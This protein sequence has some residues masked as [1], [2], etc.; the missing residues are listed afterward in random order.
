MATTEEAIAMLQQ[1]MRDEHGAVIL[2]L[3]HAYFM[4]EGEEAAEIEQVARDEMRHFKWLAQAITQLG[5]VPTL[6]RTAMEV[7][8][9]VAAQWMR[10][11][12][13]AEQ[14]AIAQ[15]ERHRD[16]IA[17]PRVK[18]LLERIL[19]DERAHLGT[20]QSLQ[21]KFSSQGGGPGL[22]APVDESAHA[23]AAPI[24]D[25]GTTHEY[26]V[27]LQY[28]FHSFLT[29]DAEV[30]RELETVAINEM[31]HL[32][33]LAEFAASIGHKPLMAHD[34]VER[35]ART[36]QMLQADLEAER[37][38]TRRYN[39]YLAQLA[40]EPNLAGLVEV[41][42]RAR[43]NELFHSHIFGLMLSRLA[44]GERPHQRPGV[45][46]TQPLSEEDTAARL[47]GQGAGAAN[48]TASP[49]QTSSPRPS[50]TVGGLTS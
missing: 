20:F 31:Q 36:S 6:D 22:P 13:Q 3:L 48:Q 46:P 24:L 14:D 32:G 34:P 18:A 35:K 50:F 10:R 30:S 43:D 28:L 38:V 27:I 49:K 25:Y 29:P 5:G 17:D 37:A 7:G 23:K 4:G 21:A 39:D 41:I 26:T 11:D 1:D 2:Y 12:V 40:Q 15:Y 19:T 9:E 33:W 45:G 44:E 47:D 8:G 42:E 16:A